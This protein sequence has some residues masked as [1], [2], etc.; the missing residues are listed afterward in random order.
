MDLQNINLTIVNKYINNGMVPYDECK[1]VCTQ[2]CNVHLIESALNSHYVLIY[3]ALIL[4]F[5]ASIVFYYSSR[6]EALCLERGIQWTPDKTK[7]LITYMLLG[8]LI[9]LLIFIMFIIQ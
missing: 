2:N 7:S 4:L 1:R 3:L 5:F 6:F 8:T 9:L